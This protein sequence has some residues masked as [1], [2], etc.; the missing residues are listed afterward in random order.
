MFRM[1]YSIWKPQC[2]HIFHLFVSK[3]YCYVILFYKCSHFS[4]HSCV[5][6]CVCVFKTVSCAMIYS[7][8]IKF[9]HLFTLHPRC[10]LHPPLLVLFHPLRSPPPIHSPS[11]SVQ[12]R[13]GNLWKSTKHSKQSCSTTK[14]L[15]CTK[16]VQGDP[17]WGVG[18]QSL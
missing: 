6:V 16:A 7:L 8:K 15:P 12:E 2:M 5:C 18:F 3:T 17:E 10:N 1:F 11:I 13:A 4:Q 14:H 9:V